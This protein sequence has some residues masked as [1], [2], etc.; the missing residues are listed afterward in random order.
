[1]IMNLDTNDLRNLNDRLKSPEL[2]ALTAVRMARKL[3]DAGDL[4]GC[5]SRLRGELDKL[6]DDALYPIVRK[7]YEW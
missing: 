4:E 7:Y 6:R 2:Q 5:M 3:H 1:M